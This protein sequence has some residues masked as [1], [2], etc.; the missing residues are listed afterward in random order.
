[1]SDIQIIRG[2]TARFKFQRLDSNG[3]P[4]MTRANSVFFTVKVD[5]R[6]P[7]IVI[8]KTLK[9]MTLDENGVYRFTLDPVDTDGLHFRDYYYDLEIITENTKTTIAYGRFIINPE[10]TWAQNESEE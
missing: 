6:F 10:V 1:M 2:D 4:I 9:D 3:E 5:Y 7:D 8:Q